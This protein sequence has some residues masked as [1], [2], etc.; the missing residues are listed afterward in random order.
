MIPLLKRMSKTMFK[1]PGSWPRQ[2]DSVVI[3]ACE[4]SKSQEN[5]KE[6]Y[7]LCADG[8]CKS[9]SD[10]KGRCADGMDGRQLDGEMQPV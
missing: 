4:D 1:Y 9:G 3:K 6:R 8:L 7:G 10:G 2:S 5:Y